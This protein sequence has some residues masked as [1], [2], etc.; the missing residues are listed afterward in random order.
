MCGDALQTFKNTSSPN[1]E[2]LEEILRVFCGEHVKLQ[3]MST[4]KH[5]LQQLVFNPVNQ[6]SI[7]FFIKFQKLVKAAFWFAC[8]AS[9]EQLMYANMPLHL[10]KSMNQAHLEN[11]N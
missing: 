3:S 4:A 9:F 8:Q 1:R 6:N 11:G 7:D 2:N 5:K 10:K